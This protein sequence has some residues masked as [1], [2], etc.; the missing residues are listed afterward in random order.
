MFVLD[1]VS[2]EFVLDVVN[3]FEAMFPQNSDTIDLSSQN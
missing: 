1:D 3:T 2:D